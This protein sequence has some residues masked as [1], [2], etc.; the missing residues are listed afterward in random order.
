M[1]KLSRMIVILEMSNIILYFIYNSPVVFKH[2]AFCFEK[3]THTQCWTSQSHQ[4]ATCAQNK[5]PN[6][7][8]HISGRDSLGCAEYSHGIRKESV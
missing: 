6:E 1:T 8:K 5:T 2:I 7:T 3:N 4:G